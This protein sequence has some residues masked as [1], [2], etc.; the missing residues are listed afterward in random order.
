MTL[1]NPS[2]P[3]LS[4]ETNADP[5]TLYWQPTENHFSGDLSRLV[6]GYAADRVVQHDGPAY[7]SLYAAGSILQVAARIFMRPHAN[8]A[9]PI[10]WGSGL[11]HPVDAS[12]VRNVDIALVRGP[13][14]AALL[15]VSSRQF[16]DPGLLI[17]EA[18]GFNATQ[19]D[20]IGLVPDGDHCDSPE[21]VA[22]AARDPRLILID[23]RQS[24]ETV[25]AQVAS[26]AHIYTSALN[27]LIA[28]DAYGVSSTWMDPGDVPLLPYYDY[29]AA[30]ERPLSVPLPWADLGDHLRRLSPAGRLP[31][32]DA[33]AAAQAALHTTFPAPLRA[34]TDAVAVEIDATQTDTPRG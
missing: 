33:I 3:Q 18:L 19:Q 8:G 10:I 26:C 25:C 6:T 27:G 12:F 22:L 21:L 9:R 13:V 28:A 32:A 7:A 17:A 4:T 34:S 15:G 11:L 24:A 20:Q 2:F 1:P 30:I 23:V 14:T 5:I 29:A 16:G 31:Y